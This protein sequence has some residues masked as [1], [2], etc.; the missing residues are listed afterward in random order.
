M[1]GLSKEV[2][3]A[4]CQRLQIENI[5]D[6]K[7]WEKEFESLDSL[8]MIDLVFALEDRFKIKFPEKLDVSSIGSFRHIVEYI[9]GN[10]KNK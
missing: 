7:E 3:E 6:E 10:A 4:M 9:R 1:D 5:N 8:D 2:S